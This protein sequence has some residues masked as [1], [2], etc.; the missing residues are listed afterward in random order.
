MTRLCS[1]RDLRARLGKAVIGAVRR[2]RNPIL[3]V[4][5]RPESFITSGHTAFCRSKERDSLCG[6]LSL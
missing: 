6:Q 5:V 3:Q 4:H 1:L 2:P